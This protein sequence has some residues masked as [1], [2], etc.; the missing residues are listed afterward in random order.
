M[1]FIRTA[2]LATTILSAGGSLAQAN[3]KVVT[4]I[5]PVHSLVSAVMAGVGEPSLLVKGGRVAA[6]IRAEA[7]AGA[8]ASGC[9]A[10]VLDEP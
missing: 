7:I 6:H 9:G 2:F 8:A 10:G 3:V 1:R 4:S 5:K